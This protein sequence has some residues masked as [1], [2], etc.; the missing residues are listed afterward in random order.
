MKT[1]HKEDDCGHSDVEKGANQISVSSPNEIKGHASSPKEANKQQCLVTIT[2]SPQ[3]SAGGETTHRFHPASPLFTG[4]LLYSSTA[5]T[6][7][8]AS[9]SAPNVSGDN[10][11]TVASS[12]ISA[13]A[14]SGFNNPQANI[15]LPSISDEVKLEEIAKLAASG[16]KVRN[17][18]GNYECT[19][20]GKVFPTWTGRYYHMPLHTGKWKHV[21]V[22]CD[23]KF[24]RTDRYEQHLDKHRQE[25]NQMQ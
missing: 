16:P 2:P 19:F 7:A 17:R 15:N 1:D 23:K 3:F 18:R 12:A 11:Q 20:C 5:A 4:S 6:C 10:V 8:S 9:E 21:C 24:M 22:I 14:S 13:A 25:L